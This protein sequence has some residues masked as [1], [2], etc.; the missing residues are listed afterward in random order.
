MDNLDSREN[1]GARH[2][3]HAAPDQAPDYGRAGRNV[4]VSIAVGLTLLGAVLLPLFYLK[5]FFWLV[6]SAAAAIGSWEMARA[7]RT[8]GARAPIGPLIGGSAAIIALAWY[9]GMDGLS[10]GLLIA[11]LAAMVWRMGEGPKGYQ[12]D[13]G[14]AALVLVYVPFLLGFAALLSKPSDG[15]WR[16]LV[17]LGAVVLSD[18][19]GYVAGVLFGRHPMAPSISPKKSWEGFAGSMVAAAV[20]GSLLLWGLLDLAP[21]KGVVFGVVVSAAAI[22]GDL[23][24]SLI[25]R[26]LGVKDMSALLP[27]HGGLMDRLDSILFAVPTSYLLLS[28][29][30]R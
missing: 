13:I 10:I 16:I 15:A 19:G 3:R 7:M 20:G 8:S 30:A 29:L 6:L 27:G 14:A 9:S 1:S 5:D 11:V 4:P 21:W 28:V 12:R 25:K 24:E 26:D 2:V 17:T 18:T 22:L 23:A